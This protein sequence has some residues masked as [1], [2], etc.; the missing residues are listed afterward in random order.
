MKLKVCFIGIGSIAKRH[1]KNLN[2]ICVDRNYN[3]QIDVVRHC[4]DS[5]KLED[6]ILKII[7]NQ[8][9]S[10][11]D[12]PND[13][14]A[15][16]ITNP[17]KYHAETLKLVHNKSTHF[18]IEKPITSIETMNQ[19][20]NFQIRDDYLYYVA[21]PLR[22]SS[23]IQYIKKE[24]KPEDIISVRSVSSSY[25]P[26]WRPLC[27]YRETYSAHKSMGGGVSID[28]IHEWDYLVYLFGTPRSC[29]F[30][31]GKISDLEIDSDDFAIYLAKYEDKIVELH[32]DY[33]GKKTIRE[34]ML[35]TKYDTIIG[36]LAANK[37]NFLKAQKQID[38]SEQRND[39]QIRELEYFLDLV[40]G[41]ERQ[42]KSDINHALQV[43]KLT[44]GSI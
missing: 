9:T 14:D 23:V 25:L 32:L 38:F 36:D 6:E 28:L 15:V 12:L 21:C 20:E 7:C 4:I 17:T 34:I 8:Y 22:Y 35:I 37:V 10:V 41:K 13:Y 40:T 1:I 44:Q 3:L 5:K 31:N 2:Q 33:F 24:I 42:E 19:M 11:D 29:H 30:L 26:D 27:D 16:F 43:L 39:Y 18:F